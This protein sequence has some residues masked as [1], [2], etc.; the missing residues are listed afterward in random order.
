MFLSG[1]VDR[2]QI[3]RGMEMG[4]DDCLTKP[5]T[6]SELLAAANARLEKQKEIRDQRTQERHHGVSAHYHGTLMTR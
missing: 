4:A 2:P 1:A 5:F 6:P 3:R